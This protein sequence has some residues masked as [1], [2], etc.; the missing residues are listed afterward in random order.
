MDC[1]LSLWENRPVWPS[2]FHSSPELQST[3][4]GSVHSGRR[5]L[6]YEQGVWLQTAH[7]KTGLPSPLANEEQKLAT[8]T[9][10][11]R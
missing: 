7:D 9:T 1:R 6:R 4:L 11:P 5:T 8:E 2:A 3:C 10:L